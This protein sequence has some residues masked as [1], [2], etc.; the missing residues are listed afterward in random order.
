[1]EGIVIP[2]VSLIGM[3]E[4]I[5]CFLIFNN[6]EFLNKDRLKENLYWYLKIE[7]FFITINFFMQV[8]RF[9]FFEPT[10]ETTLLANIYRLYFL[11]FF[12]G[13]LEMSALICRI[14]STINF[15]T[16]LTNKSVNFNWIH[17]I[18]KYFTT[19][20]IFVISFLLLF[21]TTVCFYIRDDKI[22]EIDGFNLTVSHRVYSLG[23]TEFSRSTSK[24][25]IQTAVYLI[26]DLFMILFLFI[27]DI[28]ICLNVVNSLKSKKK[29]LYAANNEATTSFEINKESKKKQ[30]NKINRIQRANIKIVMMIVLA[31][32]N[33]IFGRIPV[34]VQQI[35]ENFIDMKDFYKI[36]A[37]MVYMS[38]VVNFFI[39]ICFNKRFRKILGRYLS[40]FRKCEKIRLRNNDE[41]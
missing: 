35:L 17:K 19:L 39:Y 18:S 14:T 7:A 12:A 21:Y 15:Y 13:V 40:I 31:S 10:I 38:Y 34:L 9:L 22:E 24:K 4:Y 20:M 8:L 11:I 28:L 37:L 29:L 26:R 5:V 30:I 16:I 2:L 41:S 3:L 32:F 33:N 6:A 25:I 27:L 36:A 23:V 1:M